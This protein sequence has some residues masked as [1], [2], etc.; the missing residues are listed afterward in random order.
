MIITLI[1]VALVVIGIVGIIIDF[2]TDKGFPAEIYMP[3]FVVGIATL[4]V[5]LA[6]IARYR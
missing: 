4:I 1:A 2:N 6:I 5:S 3:S